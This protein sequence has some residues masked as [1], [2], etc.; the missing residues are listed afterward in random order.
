M[1]GYLFPFCIINTFTR[2]T[3]SFPLFLKIWFHLTL[4]LSHIF[5]LISYPPLHRFPARKH[6]LIETLMAII[7]RCHRTSIRDKITLIPSVT[8]PSQ[9]HPPFT[10][11]NSILQGLLQITRPRTLE[12]ILRLEIIL[13]VILPSLVPSLP[14][15]SSNPLTT[16]LFILLGEPSLGKHQPFSLTC[17][18]MLLYL[19]QFDFFITDCA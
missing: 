15:S 6:F 10:G 4:D 2:Y 7:I 8:P 13:L 9:S 12:P 1:L 17:F 18:H 19:I 5:G 16:F 14:Q 11:L 3:Q